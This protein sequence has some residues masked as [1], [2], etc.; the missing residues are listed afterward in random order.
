MIFHRALARPITSILAALTLTA[1]IFSS[2]PGATLAS[3]DAPSGS[4]ALP[5]AAQ[6]TPAMLADLDAYAVD[7]LHRFGIP[8]ASVAIVQG[9]RTVHARGFGVA[10]LGGGQAVSADTLFLIGSI[11]KGMTAQLIGTLVDDGV[12]TWDP[13][14][15]DVLP[16]FAMSNPASTETVTF[17]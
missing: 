5:P 1:S 12:L 8:G 9:G 4:S 16:Q 13:R 3:Q 7:A 15:V 10:E 6:L 11:G 17:R 14:I 2:Q